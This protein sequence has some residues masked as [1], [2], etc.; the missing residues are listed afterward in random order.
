V[1]GHRAAI[2]AA[3]PALGPLYREVAR[4]TVELLAPERRPVLEE[5][6]G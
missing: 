1:A 5:A 2:A 4:A 3:H 6:L